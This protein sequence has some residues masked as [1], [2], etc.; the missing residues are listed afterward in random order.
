MLW[1]IFHRVYE[2]SLMEK[3]GHFTWDLIQVA[4]GF[5]FCAVIIYKLLLRYI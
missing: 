5:M 1:E 4:M 2:F 3:T